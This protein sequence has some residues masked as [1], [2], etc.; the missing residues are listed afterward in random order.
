MR[1]VFLHGE[2]GNSLGR[3]W[4]LE[5][6]SIQEAL[7][8]IEA[9]T[10]KLTQF[11]MKNTEKFTHYT[12]AIDDKNLEEHQLKSQI[13][14]NNRAIHIM[15]QV[16][17]G[18]NWIIYIVVMIVVNLIIQAIFKPPKPKDAIETSSYLFAG[19]E[20][21]AGQGVPVPVGYGRLLVGSV[22]VS[23]AV[24]H[25]EYSAPKKSANSPLI[26]G[27]PL[28]FVWGYSQGDASIS[29]PV[30]IGLGNRIYGNSA[31]LG[32]GKIYLGTP[33]AWGSNQT[34]ESGTKA[35]ME[36]MYRF[37]EDDMDELHNLLDPKDSVF[38]D[39]F[40]IWYYPDELFT[41]L[42]EAYMRKAGGGE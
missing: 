39:E 24:R 5:V 4:D 17:G 1:K 40:H 16:A 19:T 18:V 12:F 41:E 30:A 42:I 27:V 22:V 38:S 25:W 3:E 31:L 36:E 2:L 28:G 9:N 7:W 32:D 23:A 11:L 13:G 8:A 10:N 37:S 14:D 20:N 26:N 35:W 15:P 34:V 29:T 21:V 6:D 33:E